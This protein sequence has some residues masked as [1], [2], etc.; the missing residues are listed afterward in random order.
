MSRS[1]LNIG[2]FINE[3]AEIRREMADIKT[4]QP[5]GSSQIRMRISENPGQWDTSITPHRPGQVANSDGWNVIIVTAR[6]INDSNLVG[7][8]AIS[9]SS[10]SAIYDVVGI[11]LPPSQNNVMKWFVPVFGPR[12]QPIQL[13]FQIIANDDCTINY[14]EWSAW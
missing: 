12:T 1:R 8:L 4:R 3:I 6:S 2:D 7:R 14:E 10:D 5:I 9:A 13:K 11:P